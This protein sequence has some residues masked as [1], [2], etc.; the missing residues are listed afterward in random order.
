MRVQTAEKNIL[1]IHTTPVHQFMSCEA[2]ICV[3]TRKKC[4]IKICF[5]FKQLL[6]YESAIYNIASSNEKVILSESGENHGQIKSVQVKQ[7]KKA[8][9][10]CFLSTVWTLI[11]TAPVHCRGHKSVLMKTKLMYMLDGLSTFLASR[12]CPKI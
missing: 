4:I 7:S 5:Y 11:L 12:H 8:L 1:I 2:N 6:K 3:F 10:T 9:N